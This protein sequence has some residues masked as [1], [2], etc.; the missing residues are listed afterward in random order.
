[1]L[2]NVIFDIILIGILAAGALI[3]YK[4]G[5]I[6]TVARPVKFVLALVIAF[7]L[8]RTVGNVLVEPL[9]GPAISHKLTDIL[10]EKY[11]DVTATTASSEL[12]TLVKI[13]ASFCGVDIQQVATVSDGALVIES[14]ANAVAAPVVSLISLVL[15]FIVAHI[16]AKLVLKFLL[17]LI[18]TLVNNGIAGVV[19]R[20]LGCVFTL[21]LAFVVG[22]GITC[23]SEFI[24]NIPAIASAS[25]VENFTGGAIYRFFRTFTPLDLLLSF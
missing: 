24:F 20:T 4:N 23:I 6:D 16:L 11:A 25:G 12:P 7:S 21:F 13:A 1:M 17:I 8:A 2:A 5:F 19:N 18:N 3:G 14:I 15:G 10:V 22:W 9:I